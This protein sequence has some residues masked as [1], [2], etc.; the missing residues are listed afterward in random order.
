MKSKYADVFSERECFA[1]ASA[2][3]HAGNDADA[4]QWVAVARRL[5]CNECNVL[6]GIPM[7]RATR[8]YMFEWATATHEISCPLE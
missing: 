5:H 3:Q 8:V 6:I 1:E 7:D 2:Q 4:R